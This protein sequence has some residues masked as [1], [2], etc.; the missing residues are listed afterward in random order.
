MTEMKPVQPRRGI[1]GGWMS[2][3]I[4]LVL[5]VGVLAVVYIWQN[6]SDD[7]DEDNGSAASSDIVIENAWVRA[8]TGLAAAPVV[9]EAAGMDMPAA[10]A[11]EAAG[12]M[13]GMDMPAEAT[14]AAG[15]M[16]GMEMGSSDAV[17]AA[18]MTI[19]NN[20][21]EE[22][23]LTAVTCADTR[24]VQ[25]HETTMNG[26]VMQMRP[27]TEGL[28]IPADSTVTLE[29]GGIHLM[30]LGFDAD[31]EPGQTV[32]LVLTFA[33]GKELTVDAEVRTGME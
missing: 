23:V 30:L 15:D 31:F 24:E 6:G 32:Q 12:D 13:A 29:P 25:I 18:Y 20:A 11:T 17:T 10:G 27:L 19:T 28:T 1:R 14:E 9:T 3:A 33:S 4:G 2:W 5:L 26:D 16:G 7:G 22:D 8:T 21:D